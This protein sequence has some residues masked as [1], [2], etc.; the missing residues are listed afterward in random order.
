[1][2]ILSLE[3]KKKNIDGF[4]LFKHLLK[5]QKNV[6]LSNDF[7]KRSDKEANFF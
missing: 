3:H 6:E 4:V 2:N 1:M 7:L 5:N